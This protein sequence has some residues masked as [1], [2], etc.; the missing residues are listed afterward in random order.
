MLMRSGRS[1]PCRVSADSPSARAA[2]VVF[3]RDGAP[4]GGAT[5]HPEEPGWTPYLGVDDVDA[6]GRTAASAGAVITWG[7]E[8]TPYGRIVSV[9]DPTGA[10][11]KLIRPILGG[12]PQ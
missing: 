3:T 10:P 8:D 1:G 12:G 2:Y 11:F 7:P 5:Q 4:V 6:A 9:T